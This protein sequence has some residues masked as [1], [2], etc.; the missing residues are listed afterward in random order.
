[1]MT[2]VESKICNTFFETFSK[3]YLRRKGFEIKNIRTFVVKLTK[4]SSW[5]AHQMALFQLVPFLSLHILL[6]M[7]QCGKCETEY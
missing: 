1:M 5:C 3:A 7:L 6:Y 4:N 2:T